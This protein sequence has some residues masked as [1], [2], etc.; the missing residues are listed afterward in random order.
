M[1]T[2]PRARRWI[3]ALLAL[4]ALGWVSAVAGGCA[5]R[6]NPQTEP[7]VKRVRFHEQQRFFRWWR[8]TSNYNLRSAMEQQSSPFGAAI[9]GQTVELDLDTLAAD[10]WRVELWYAHHGFF[11]AH[12]DGWEVRTLRP[13]RRGRPAVVEV[14][15]YVDEGEESFVEEIVFDGLTGAAGGAVRRLVANTAPLQEGDRFSVDAHRETADL[16]RST[17]Q[18][19]SYARATVT[20]E[21]IANPEEH[22]V[23][24]RYTAELGPPCTFGEVTIEGFET[25]PENIIRDNI[26]VVEG[27]AFNTSDLAETQR[28]L[29]GLGTFS[30]VQVVPQIPEEGDVVPVKVK[31]SESRF[32]QLKVGPGVGIQSGEQM[33]RAQLGFN[34][35]NLF[36][37]LLQLETSAVVGY[38]TFGNFALVRSSEDQVETEAAQGGPFVSLEGGLDWPRFFTRRLSFRQEI[39]T[40]WDREQGYEYVLLS[41]VPSFSY[42]LSP[43][44]TLTQAFHA[45]FWFLTLEE[46]VAAPDFC[47]DL[48]EDICR[49]YRLIYPQQQ[50][51]WDGRDNPLFTTRGHYIKA[52]VYEA[53]VLNSVEALR[54]FRF[55][56]GEL[57]LRRY[58]LIREPFLNVLAGRIGA[59]VARPWG[60]DGEL[61]AVPTTERF[62]LGGST[63]VRGWASGYL[64]PR[65]CYIEGSDGDQLVDLC[66]E[67]DQA[68]TV[69]PLGGQAAVWGSLEWR[70]PGPYDV[71]FAFFTDAGMVWAEIGDVVFTDIQPTAGTGLRYATPIGPIRL[72]I[73][74]RLRRDDPD[75][76]LD[77]PY[78]FHFSLSEAF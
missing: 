3:A 30:L 4:L 39:S 26:A 27:R 70:I 67:T 56:R 59:G 40:T 21:V 43:R 57:D 12:F 73:A 24:V 41:A 35:A 54:G 72:D 36:E 52:S 68:V 64:G 38:K 9:S 6:R 29:F 16:L 25:V 75:F 34:H 1:S 10:A 17:L 48:A 74:F 45:E 8:G 15:G 14:V 13:P 69:L 37:R 65:E 49:Q 63:D 46:G 77:K 66:E 76:V 11:D 53:G 19:R 44:I 61:S 28:N 32:R 60:D 42:K 62:F 31:L 5:G 71:T 51:V 55:V 33:V 18:Q 22:S 20:S 7:S 50:L 2:P 47:G 58:L 78:A 23:K